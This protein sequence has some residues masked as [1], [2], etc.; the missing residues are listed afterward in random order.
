MYIGHFGVAL[1][2]KRLAPRTSLGTLFAATEFVDMLWPVLVLSG[3]EHV[4]IVPGITKLT[5]LDFYDYPISHSLMM[6]CVWASI[7]ALGYWLV[8]RYARGA[9]VAGALVMSHWFLDAVVHRPDLPVAPWSRH[10][11]GLGLW[12]HIFA[13]VTLELILFLGGLW[14]YASATVAKDRVGGIALWSL[15]AFLLLTWAANILGPPPPNVRAVGVVGVIAGVLLVAWAA[16]IDHHRSRRNRIQADG[17]LFT[18]KRVA[19]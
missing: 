1:A 12:N 6:V 8:R 5:P 18:E 3:I 19:I 7:F 15:V 2:A 10:L 14:L 13:A 17:E 4:R 11:M 16:W 9:W